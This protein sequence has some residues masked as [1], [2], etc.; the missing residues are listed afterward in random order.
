MAITPLTPGAFKATNSANLLVKTRSLL[1]DLQ[2]QLATDRKAESYGDLGTKRSTALNFRA[3][4]SEVEGYRDTITG[5]QVRVKQLDL[6]FTQLGKISD[7]AR[8]AGVLPNFDPDS[9]GKTSMQR[10][11]RTRF[12][13]AVDV[14]NLNVGGVYYLSG[15]KAD[16]VPVLPAETILNGDAAGRAGVKQLI[17]ERKAADYG[18]AASAGRV[19]RGGAGATATLT[20]D[21]AHPFGFKL[22]GASTSSAAITA[23]RTVGP[24]ANVSFNVTGT[25]AVGDEVRLQ[26]TLPDG[27]TSDFTLQARSG[28]TAGGGDS[29]GFDIGATPAAT[30]TNL[31]TALAALLDRESTTSLNAASA[32]AASDAFF[33]GSLSSPPLRVVGPP[34][35]AT[36]LAA[37]TAAD[38]VI[39]YRGDDT[40]TNPRTTTQAKVDGGLT[41]GVGA[42]ANEEG[43]R[44]LLSN[45]AAFVSETYT[46]G[47]ATDRGR[48]EELAQRVRTDLGQRPGA[49]RVQ[50]I[51]AEIALAGNVMTQAE[52]RHKTKTGFVEGIIGDIENTNREETAAKLLSLQTKLQA[53]YQTTS[54][55]S[56]L[57]LTDYLR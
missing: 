23:T 48:F 44:R 33:A 6:S 14:L 37:G 21:G 20:E 16:T 7:D 9:S 28:P 24:P 8:S 49:Q 42:Q 15:R 41:I 39:W 12:E 34:A 50:D 26:L 27:T 38:T 57:T 17:A 1:D 11:L 46:P 29:G 5:F 18:V 55:I 10:Q 36:A 35:T 22:S 2:R 51:Q 25:P 4:L 47:S 54:I 45:L 13:E 19:L 3:K 32:K 31:R 52:E 40:S 30:A 43:V 53:A 56:R